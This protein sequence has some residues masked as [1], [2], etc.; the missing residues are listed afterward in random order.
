MKVS[1]R[2]A[3]TTFVKTFALGA[4]YSTSPG[5]AWAQIFLL[6]VQ[7]IPDFTP[8]ILK[9]NLN[10]FP[11]LSQP[12][13][14]VRLGTAPVGA[15][16]TADEAWLKPIIINRGEGDDYHVVSAVCTHQGCIVRRMES[17]S[18][19]M[20][21]PCH[22]SQFEKDGTVPPERVGNFDLQPGQSPLQNYTYTR[23]GSILLITVPGLF[24]DVTFNRAPLNAR[25][26]LRFVAF[27]QTRYEIYFRS[28]LESPPTL[29]NFSLTEAGPANLTEIA[30][31]FESDYVTLYLDRPGA[32]GF[33]QLAVKTSQV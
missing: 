33:F 18:Q 28:T 27:Y 16:N 5:S 9:I 29:V 6:E 19:R 24:F 20:V 17:A 13:G 4:A 23:Q 8:G 15:N 21:C 10:D 11:V 30:G 14:S 12:L 31:S 32:F 3:L 25:V 26:Q 2:E 1:R 22:G 7:Q